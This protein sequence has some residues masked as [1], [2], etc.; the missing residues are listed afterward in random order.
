MLRELAGALARRRAAKRCRDGSHPAR[1]PAV[2]ARARGGGGARVGVGGRIG[3]GVGR[4][5]GGG[6]VEGVARRDARRPAAAGR[7]R[8]AVP[9]RCAGACR[10][11]DDLTRWAS[12]VL[13]RV[14][15]WQAR[16]DEAR[17]LVDDLPRGDV[18]DE[19]SAFVEAT[20]VRVLLGAGDVFAAGRRLR[21]IGRGGGR[22]VAEPAG[23][24]DRRR[25]A[26]PV[27]LRR[28]R[29]EP[30]GARVQRRASGSPGPRG[31]RCGLCA[32]GLSGWRRFS[33][34][35][36]TRGPLESWARTRPSGPV[37]AAVAEGSTA[38]GRLARDG[39]RRHRPRRTAARA[40]GWRALVDTCRDSA[41]TDALTSA[42]RRA[43]DGVGGATPRASWTAEGSAPLAAIGEGPPRAA[44]ARR[45]SPGAALGPIDVA[46]GQEVAVPIRWDGR[47]VAALAARWDRAPAEAAPWLTAAAAIL[48]ARVVT[49]GAKPRGT[50]ALRDADSR[51]AGPQRRHGRGAACGR[52]RGPGAR[53]P[54]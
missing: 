28:G 14:S 22:G 38:Q 15:M 5:E 2:G 16:S 50:S 9:R 11:T 18:V 54:C 48:A 39:A 43:L 7:S 29:S 37:R 26:S 40:H 47:V 32:P 44:P 27:P 36:R 25:R 20:A 10:P 1:L 46:G 35:A 33:A 8:S 19:R 6:G 24:G 34:P 52:S 49:P 3:R 31:R 45:C 13:A 17:A 30:R 42:V 51:P 53:L 21:G 4:R 23:A 12:A 41:K